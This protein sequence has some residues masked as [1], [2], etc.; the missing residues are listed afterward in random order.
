MCIR[1]RFHTGRGRVVVRGKAH[2]ESDNSGRE[3]IIISEIPYQVNKAGLVE[4]IAEM[5]VEEKITGI[6]TIRDESDRNGLR[7]VVEVK[8]DAMASVVLSKLYKFTPLQTSYGVNNIAL[9]NG[10]P[11]LLNIRQ[12]IDEFVKFRIEVIV[13]RTRYELRKAEERAHILAGLLIEMCIRDR[14][15]E[16]SEKKPKVPIFLTLPA[17]G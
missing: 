14:V 10:R 2:I 12:M 5:M 13:R 11:R 16:H 9:V 17:L 15:I 7:V 8:K 4:K 1:D 3:T 6:S